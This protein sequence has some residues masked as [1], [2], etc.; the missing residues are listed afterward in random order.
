MK[1]KFQYIILLALFAAY[2]CKKDNYDAPSVSLKGR[3]LYN[4]EAVNVEYNRVPFELYQPGFGKTGA[5]SGTFGQDGSY[6]TLLFAGDYKFTISANQGPFRWKE[7]SAGKRDTLAVKVSGNQ[8]LDIDVTP[9][10]MIRNAAFTASAGK[11]KATFNIEKVINDANAKNIETV[12]LYIN[13]TQFVSAAD[14][15]NINTDPTVVEPAK[16]TG[17][18]ITDLNN[19]IIT[20]DI[21]SISPTQN[22][23]FA[24]VGIKI[25]GVED[26]IFS[27]LVKVSY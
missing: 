6:S 22:Y 2:G 1:I 11:L 25:A 4:G 7:L 12:T 19:I 15:I 9:Y 8:T 18:S 23:V 20:D 27:P 24:R 3:L 26:L 10:Y 17:S 21:P 16:V 5:I 14:N 13:K